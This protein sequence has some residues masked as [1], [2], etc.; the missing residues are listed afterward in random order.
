MGFNCIMPHRPV[1][2]NWASTKDVGSES[3][4][5]FVYVNRGL[6]TV[7][8]VLG[9]IG[10]GAWLLCGNKLYVHDNEF[11]ISSDLKAIIYILTI[12]FK[13]RSSITSVTCKYVG[14]SEFM[15][16]ILAAENVRFWFVVGDSTLGN[17]RSKNWQTGL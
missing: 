17:T 3:V 16:N 7:F 8:V 12:D 14:G 11:M 10:G 1:R 15:V 4:D 13:C 5:P 2:R 6:K 9:A